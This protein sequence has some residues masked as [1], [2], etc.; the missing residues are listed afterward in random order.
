MNQIIF[1]F[2]AFHLITRKYCQIEFS[3]NLK[4]KNAPQLGNCQRLVIWQMPTFL[5][6]LGFVQ[7]KNR[8]TAMLPG[9]RTRT[10][11]FFSK[12]QTRTGPR[13]PF[14]VEKEWNQN[15]NQSFFKKL[16]NCPTLVQM[17]L[18]C[19]RAWPQGQELPP[20]Q[21]WAQ[22]NPLMGPALHTTKKNWHNLNLPPWRYI[23]DL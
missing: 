16:N 21:A 11:I 23:S 19:L 6:N 15:W 9:N 4:R 7:Q 3:C 17:G 13:V 14:F 20:S 8:S 18:C 5:L 10:W 2:D 1:G 12:N 22:H